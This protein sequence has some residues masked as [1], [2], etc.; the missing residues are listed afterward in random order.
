MLTRKKTMNV[1]SNAQQ[2]KRGQE[3]AKSREKTLT[4]SQKREKMSGVS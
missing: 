2:D 1:M 3:K 4:N